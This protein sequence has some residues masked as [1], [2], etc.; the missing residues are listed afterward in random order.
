MKTYTPK[1]SEVKKRWFVVDAKNKILGRLATEVATILMGKNKPLFTPHL[2]A[3][4]YVIVI[5]ADKVILS[6]K[7]EKTKNY[8]RY[9]GY[10]GGLKSVTFSKYL[11]EKPEELFIHSVK[12]MLPKNRLGRKMLSKLFVYRGDKHPHQA[13]KPEVLKI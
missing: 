8:Y 4:D 9:S 5:N 10:P 12:G 3:G 11:K 13:Q 1:M 7:K 2:D 6:G